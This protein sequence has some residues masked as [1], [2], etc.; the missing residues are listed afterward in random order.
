M[1][2]RTDL[3]RR[4]V[5]W[6]ADCLRERGHRVHSAHDFGVDLLIGGRTV[7]VRVARATLSPRRVRHGGKVYNSATSTGG[8]TSTRTERCGSTLSSTSA[9]CVG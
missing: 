3:H 6:V 1:S 4:G 2:T 5:A 8:S 9:C 7:A